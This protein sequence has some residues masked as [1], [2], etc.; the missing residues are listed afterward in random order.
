MLVGRERLPAGQKGVGLESALG[1]LFGRRI[2]Y[3]RR[4]F[5]LLPGGDFHLGAIC[6]WMEGRE[7]KKLNK[8]SEGFVGKF[9]LI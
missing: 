8:G 5:R 6:K 7:K 1:P 2:C 3:R 4:T 9:K